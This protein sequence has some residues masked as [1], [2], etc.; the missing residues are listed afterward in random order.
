MKILVGA[1]CA[2]LAM[3]GPAAA[4]QQSPDDFVRVLLMQYAEEE[5]GYLIGDVIT[6]WLAQEE[7]VSY[8]F[9]LDPSK[10]YRVYG[11]CD[12]NCSDLDLL[13]VDR[14]GDPVAIDVEDDDIPILIIP[15]NSSGTFVELALSMAACE[16][17]SCVGGIALFQDPD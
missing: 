4:Q 11:S 9:A 12:E 8:A 2:A 10:G 1:A 17:G 14:N 15:P 13:A 16:T 3:V 6:A 7:N 5:E